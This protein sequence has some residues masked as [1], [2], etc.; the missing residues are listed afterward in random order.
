VV[1]S[2]LGL[3]GAVLLAACLPL[4]IDAGG[5][6]PLFAA[7]FFFGGLQMTMIGLVGEH[8]NLNLKET[9]RIP[10]YIVQERLE[11]RQP[12]TAGVHAAGQAS[13]SDGSL[14]SQNTYAAPP[15]GR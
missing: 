13:A 5:W 8:L 11:S 6:P 10:R 1:F 3:M 12:A 9:R 15:A 2:F 4:G 14:A 7:I